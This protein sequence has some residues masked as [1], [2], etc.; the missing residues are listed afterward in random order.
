MSYQHYLLLLL[1][2][3]SCLGACKRD[4]GIQ[5][6]DGQI[7][8][9]DHCHDIQELLTSV[10]LV[11]NEV[12]TFA[13]RDFD[14]IGS[15]APIVDMIRLSANTDYAVQTRVLDE[16]NNSYTDV[17]P[18]IAMEKEGHQFFYTIEGA[19]LT[20]EYKD[21]DADGIPVGLETEMRT[22][23]AST[24]TMNLVLKHIPV[25]SKTGNITDG[26]TDIEVNFEVVI[27]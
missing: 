10:E 6:P 13:F 8:H 18:E 15:D 23:A 19:N 12:D 7:P 16:S 25:G 17:T 2:I 4:N 24:G 26:A 14:G 9:G 21:M 11:F 22:G 5:C 20:V 1:A 27:E 3:I